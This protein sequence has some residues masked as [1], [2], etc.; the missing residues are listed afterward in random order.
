MYGLSG[1]YRCIALRKHGQNVV[2]VALV[3]GC[4]LIA[5]LCWCQWYPRRLTLQQESRGM[6]TV[7]VCVIA[8]VPSKGR[9]QTRRLLFIQSEVLVNKA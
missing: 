7:E 1:G 8:A 9:P 3:G 5:L 4:L 6:E 2:L